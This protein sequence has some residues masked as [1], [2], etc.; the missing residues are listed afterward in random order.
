MDNAIVQVGDPVLRRRARELSR[1]EILS[2]EMQEL[3]LRMRD[4]MRAAPGVG[5]AAPQIGLPLQIAV[6]ED[7]PEYLENVPADALAI[8]ERSAVPFA[9]DAANGTWHEQIRDVSLDQ[10]RRQLEVG[11]E[12]GAVAGIHRPFDVPEE[13]TDRVRWQRSLCPRAAGS[14]QQKSQHA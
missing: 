14:R 12:R 7:R 3:F 2:V 6:V 13:R 1:D 8:R 9:K 4:V 11:S 5:L 10:N